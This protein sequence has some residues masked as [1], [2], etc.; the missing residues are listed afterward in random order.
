MVEY[1]LIFTNLA[2]LQGLPSSPK[3]S[4]RNLSA[5][6]TAQPGGGGRGSRGGG[7]GLATGASDPGAG[8]GAEEVARSRRYSGD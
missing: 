3:G 8:V 5:A 6:L 4:G 2:L 1:C 7:A